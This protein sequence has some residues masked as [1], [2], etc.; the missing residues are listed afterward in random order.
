MYS[1]KKVDPFDM[2][3]L[4]KMSKKRSNIVQLCYAALP[5]RPKRHVYN[6][7]CVERPFQKINEIT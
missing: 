1:S 6:R 4:L 3:H 7:I 2:Y 5:T